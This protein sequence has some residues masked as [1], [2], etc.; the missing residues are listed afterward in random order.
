MDNSKIKDIFPRTAFN[1]RLAQLQEVSRLPRFI[2]E[3]LIAQFCGENPSKDSLEKLSQFVRTHY[4]EPKDKDKILHDLMTQGVYRLIDEFKVETNIYLGVHE[5][6]IPSL[7]IKD[8]RILNSVVG[9][10]ENLLRSGIWGLGTLK[11]V[12]GPPADEPHS[13]VLLEELTPFQT[14]R[15]DLTEFCEKRKH[16]STEEWIDL[17]INTIGLNPDAYDEDAKLILLARLIPLVE[18]NCNIMELGPRATGKTYFYR[19]M[20][21]YTRII[22]GGRISPAI[23]FYNIATKRIGEVAMRDT[24]IFDEISKISFANPEEMMGKMKDYMVDGF[25]ERGPKKAHS[26]CSMVLMG[27]ID[28]KEEIPVENLQEAIPQFMRD[29]AFIDRINGLIPGWVLPKITKSEHHLSQEYGLATD[30]FC[31][32][33]HE[34]HKLDFQHYITETVSLGDETLIR[35]EKSIKKLA[36]GMLKILCPAGDFSEDELKI[37]MDLAIGYRQRIVDWLHWLAPQEFKAQRLTWRMR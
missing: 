23:M 34:L 8:A 9:E 6:N 4:P 3:Y 35:D 33:L 13:P 15:V 21:F 11:Y 25:F 16:F 12:P 14:P 31:E 19:N 37:C 26:T 28:I 20:S 22:S 2:S 18:P 7:S 1:K 30:Y 36:S 32:I 5:L 29:S 27:N 17:I 10:Y 24:L